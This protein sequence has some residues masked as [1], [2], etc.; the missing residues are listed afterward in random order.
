MIGLFKE[1]VMLILNV[2]VFLPLRIVSRLFGRGA[3][4]RVRGWQDQ[5]QTWWLGPAAIGLFMG[6]QMTGG[7]GG[8]GDGH[9]A[10]AGNYDAGYHGDHGGGHD[11]G[12][13]GFGGDIGGF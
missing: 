13:G 8:G 6:H 10:A 3:N 2:A 9:D 12:G 5:T 11:I 7:F 1:L 4:A